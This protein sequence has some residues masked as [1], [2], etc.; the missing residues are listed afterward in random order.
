MISG[1]FFAEVKCALDLEQ[2]LPES[3]SVSG[4]VNFNPNLLSFKGGALV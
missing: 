1:D 2:C 3:D 4:T